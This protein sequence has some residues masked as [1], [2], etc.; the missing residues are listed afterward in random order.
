MSDKKPE[1]LVIKDKSNKWVEQD[2][3]NVGS[4]KLEDIVNKRRPGV[5]LLPKM[6]ALNIP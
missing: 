5:D 3:V 6:D 2:T 1:I 4:I